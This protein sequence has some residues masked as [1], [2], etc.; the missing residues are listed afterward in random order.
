MDEADGFARLEAFDSGWI[1]RD[2]SSGDIRL[3]S[4]GQ[5]GLAGCRF[6]RHVE[7]QALEMVQVSCTV[8][9]GINVQCI[10]AVSAIE[11]SKEAQHAAAQI[12]GVVIGFAGLG[13]A[14]DDVLAD[15]AAVVVDGVVRSSSA[16]VGGAFIFLIAH[17]AIRCLFF[18]R[19]GCCLIH[20]RVCCI[21]AV[22]GFHR[23]ADH[24]HRIPA[25][26]DGRFFCIWHNCYIFKSRSGNI[27]HFRIN[28]SAVIVIVF[29]IIF[30][31]RKAALQGRT[32]ACTVCAQDAG[33]AAVDVLC[34]AAGNG[35]CIALGSAYAGNAAIGVT[36]LRAA[37]QGNR[38]A[39]GRALHD[40]TAQ[41]QPSADISEGYCI[42]L[43]ALVSFRCKG[44][45]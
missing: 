10:A 16:L 43:S 30:Q 14:A 11:V 32:N 37:K 22:D 21:A 20:E 34:R 33:C 41:D 42:S 39:L 5:H 13:I 12:D 19:F 24:I 26:A 40:H 9:F 4:D 44:K 31:N 6:F 29:F 38:I 8:P 45:C 36:G 23:A 35:D 15:R 3:A 7:V 28:F 2:D 27:T 18:R 25:G 1:G 17:D